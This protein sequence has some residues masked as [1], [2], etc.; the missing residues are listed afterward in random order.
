MWQKPWQVN[1]FLSGTILL[2]TQFFPL[3][4]RSKTL[5]DN[6]LFSW[7]G[8]GKQPE[9]NIVST[10]ANIMMMNTISTGV[11]YQIHRKSILMVK[12]Y[13]FKTRKI[14]LSFF[15]FSKIEHFL[16]SQNFTRYCCVLVE[17]YW[18][19]PGHKIKMGLL[20]PI[21]IGSRSWTRE[22]RFLKKEN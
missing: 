22:V 21:W 6:N 4:I 18:K 14:N 15:F 10:N 13:F 5:P 16:I 12:K 8:S 3:N 2:L 20:Y 7:Q 9:A 11:M 17:Q 1:N 19:Q